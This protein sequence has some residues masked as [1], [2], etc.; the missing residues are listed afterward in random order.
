MCSVLA[1]RDF[2]QGAPILPDAP[3]C[4]CLGTPLKILCIIGSYSY[5]PRLHGLPRPDQPDVADIICNECEAVVRMI[6]TADLRRTL[7][8]M[9]SSLDLASAICPHCGRSHLAN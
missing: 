9:E 2:K 6:P 1:Q 7:D 5:R 3:T 4:V 8:E